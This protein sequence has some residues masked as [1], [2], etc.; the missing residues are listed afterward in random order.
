MT[1]ALNMQVRQTTDSFYLYFFY[2]F[3]QIKNDLK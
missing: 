3:S 2:K 1:L